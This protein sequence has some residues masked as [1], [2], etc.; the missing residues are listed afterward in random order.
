[1][2]EPT[3]RYVGDPEDGGIAFVPVDKR[4]FFN[5]AEFAEAY[6]RYFCGAVEAGVEGYDK[7][8]VVSLASHYAVA[9][10]GEDASDLEWVSSPMTH[11]PAAQHKL[12]GT[13]H[14]LHYK[15]SK[16]TGDYEL[17]LERYCRLHS[18]TEWF[19]V[20][21]LAELGALIAGKD[22]R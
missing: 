5:F 11:P 7:D 20:T 22:N 17:A 9:T 19:T 8:L 16:L 12:E 13:D 2:P 6:Y 4:D 10:L 21:S 1:M 14:F 15:P 18:S 3:P